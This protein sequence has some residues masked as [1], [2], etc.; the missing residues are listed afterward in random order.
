MEVSSMRKD[1]NFFL[2]LRMSKLVY[3]LAG[4]MLL[5]I[6]LGVLG[7]LCAIFIPFFSSIIISNVA[8]QTPDFPVLTFFIWMIVF[9]ILR[10]VLH[11]GEQACNHY[12]AFKLL[13]IIRDKVF[14]TLRRLC[15]AKLDGRDSGNLIFLITSDIEALEVFYAHTISP[16]I[17]AIFTCLILLGIF[18]WI[19]PLFAVLACI[20]Y[21]VIGVIIPFYITSLGKEDG[22]VSRKQ[23]GELS[24]DVLESLR[25]MQEVLQYNI[26][27]K[28]L[29]KM[30][31]KS[32]SLNDVQ[33]K[34]KHYEGVSVAL[35][36][37]MIMLSSLGMLLLGCVLY[38]QQEVTFI[39]VLMGTVLMMSSFGPVMAL[40]NLSNNL[41]ITMASARRVLSLLDE[42][43]ITKDITGKQAATFGT[44]EVDHVSFAYDDEV[45]VKDF[46]NIFEKGKIT[47]LLG[48]SGCGKSTLLKL[49]M[50]FYEPDKGA[51]SID[52]RNIQ[53]INTKDLRDMQSF[54]TQ[55][56]VLFH[57]SIYQNI[58]IAKL[59][60]TN[61]EIEEA[62]KQANIHDFICS[63]PK[64]YDTMVAELGESLS[65][66]E[67]QRIAL[68]RAFLHDSSC[69]LMDEP[70][71][72]LDALNEA[73][74]LQNLKAQKDKTI[75]L[76]SHRL[77]TMKI[78]DKVIRVENGRVS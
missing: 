24:D 19:H 63:L 40:S 7:F 17:I 34:L 47:G 70:T 76:V 67:R 51:L 60:A 68:A 45:V 11:Y 15:P 46:T 20:A 27:Q 26:G 25:G 59:D 71:S 12:I 58:R 6:I 64:G 73:E 29:K 44:M 35:S 2:M 37:T 32:E 74:I 23:F 53:E 36:N 39:Q 22:K 10:G 77:S 55:D 61:E 69:I 18:I 33:K 41:L 65:G 3:P 5:A 9:A 49:M 38:L 14:M 28:R 13:A 50:R 56:T 30:R 78:A 4:F 52:Q 62:C 31:D 54:V 42:E 72:N 66:G 48:K 57:D 8:M 21:I 1:S 16:I 43:E 75:V